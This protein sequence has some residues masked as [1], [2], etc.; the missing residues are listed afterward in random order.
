MKK[1][2]SSIPRPVIQRLPL[3][4]RILLEA[5]KTDFLRSKDFARLT[6][7]SPSQIRRDFSYFGRFGR[8][9]KGY[10][11]KDLESQIRKILG[12]DTIWNVG[13]IGI[14]HLGTALLNYKGFSAHGFQIVAGFDIDRRKIN[15][16]INEIKI[17]PYQK[18]SRIIKEKKISIV[19]L[20]VPSRVAQKVAEEAVKAG[21]RG[22]LNFAPT[23]LN[24]PGKIKVLNIDLTAELIRLAYSLAEE[25]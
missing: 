9:G 6:N 7:F 5:R 3:Y 11:I 8:R 19:I 17:Y 12:I 21:I 23:Q 10:S 4:Y 14:G 2:K 13:I 22:I 15:R 24:L 25:K 18:L 16:I 20:T 1:K